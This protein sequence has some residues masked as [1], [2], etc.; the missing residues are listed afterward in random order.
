MNEHA[1]L[2]RGSITGDHPRWSTGEPILWGDDVRT[3]DGW[4]G[5]VVG[6]SPD[7]VLVSAISDDEECEEEFSPDDLR[8][9]SLGTS[10][11][12]EPTP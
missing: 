3:P 5:F 2:I 8:L 9:L 11:R 7:E 1:S 10:H 6:M 12:T 4:D